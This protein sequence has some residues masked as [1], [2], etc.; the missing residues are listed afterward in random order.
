[1]KW[2]WE[3]LVITKQGCHIAF[4]YYH[5]NKFNMRAAK[6]LDVVLFTSSASQGQ[7]LIVSVHFRHGSAKTGAKN[8]PTPHAK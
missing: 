6:N 2:A 7:M 5:L 4:T 1:M 8:S 3:L